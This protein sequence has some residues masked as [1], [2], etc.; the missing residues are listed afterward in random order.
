MPLHLVLLGFCHIYSFE[1]YI[2]VTSL[3]LTYYF[4]FSIFHNLDM[5]PDLGQ[6]GL[7]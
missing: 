4:Y 1:I 3:C 2:F 6:F 5:F 7:L